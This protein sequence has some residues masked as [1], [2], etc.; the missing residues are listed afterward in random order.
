[1]QLLRGNLAMPERA[2]KL[3]RELEDSL[4]FAPGFP[5]RIN[6]SHQQRL[7]LSQSEIEHS[8][9][10]KRE[11]IERAWGT[12]SRLRDIVRELGLVRYEP[13]V[14]ILARLWRE[15]ALEPVRTEVGHALLAMQTSAAWEALE[16]MID[17]S[18]H[19]SVHLGVRAVFARDPLRAFDYFEPRVRDQRI[20]S[21]PVVLEALSMFAPSG[22]RFDHGQLTPVWPDFR[23]V[24]WLRQDPRWLELC[25]RL[26]RDEVYGQAARSVLREAAPDEREAALARVRRSEPPKRIEIRTV[27]VGNLLGRY[28]SG[29]FVA[30]WQDIKSHQHIGGDFYNEV[31][32]VAEE[33]MRRV[34]G[35]ADMLSERL[36]AEGWTAL[37]GALRTPPSPNDVAVFERMEA[38]TQSL[39]P[40]SL[41][42]FWTVVGGIDLVW[43]YKRDNDPPNLGVALPMPE[44]DPL[45]VDCAGRAVHLFD[46]WEEQRDQPDPDLID[47][48]D[49]DLAP[50]ALHKANISG[51]PPYGVELPFYG[52]DPLFANEPHRL[53]FVDYLRL[54]FRWAGFP[55]LEAHADR[56]DVR[57]F[58]ATFGQGLEP[59]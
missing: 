54:S 31:L 34:A 22:Y 19:L 17:D 39:L 2:S 43:D 14:P 3:L 51:G 50:D 18:D 41:Q 9:R 12:C 1:M 48:F 6:T 11:A 59:F 28:R 45:C 7:S 30:V 5:K 38:I 53:S 32:S 4:L 15:C 33:M 29:E 25:A 13:A 24:D 40:P 58:V 21:R 37:A 10:P 26:R 46:T 56:E 16:G 42:A 27:R 8:Q 20:G 55:G 35:N 36:R 49:L 44:M 57:R 47:P 52:A 23:A